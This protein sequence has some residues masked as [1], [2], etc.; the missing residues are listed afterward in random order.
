MDGVRRDIQQQEQRRFENLY[1]LEKQQELTE[2]LRENE[3]RA[4]TLKW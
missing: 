2:K 1:I 4:D 3:Q